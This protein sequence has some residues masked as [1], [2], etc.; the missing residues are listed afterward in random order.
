MPKVNASAAFPGSVHE[1][2]VCWYDTARWPWWVDG[3]ESIE[4]VDPAWPAV[5]ASVTWVSGPAGRGRVTERVVAHVPLEGQTIETEEDDI[6]ARQEV[7][8]TPV[9]GEV[10]VAV[11]LAWEYKRRSLSTLLGVLFIRGAFASSLQTTLTR[12]GA[13]LATRA[14]S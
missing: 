9:D 8:F 14:R 2:E 4:R 6:K 3:V 12:F 1:A 5:G 13:E 10:V 7:S 11:S